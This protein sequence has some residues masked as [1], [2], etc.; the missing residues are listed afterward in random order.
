MDY[1]LS[2]PICTFEYKRASVTPLILDCG[3]TFCSDCIKELETSPTCP[4][5]RS[6]IYREYPWNFPI[7]YSLL[8]LIEESQSIS[9]LN[10]DIV[11]RIKNLKE[12]YSIRKDVLNN[13]KG[14]ICKNLKMIDDNLQ[15]LETM[16]D[17]YFDENSRIELKKQ[18]EQMEEEYEQFP[19]NNLLHFEELDHYASF[20]KRKEGTIKA[21]LRELYEALQADKVYAFKP[22]EKKLKFGELTVRDNKILVHTLTLDEIP[23]GSKTVPFDDMKDD[24]LWFY[25]FLNIRG[26]CHTSHLIQIQLVSNKTLPRFIKLCTGEMGHTYKNGHLRCEGSD[27]TT[28]D[29]DS[30]E[31]TSPSNS[32]NDSLVMMSIFSIIFPEEIKL[33]HYINVRSLFPCEKESMIIREIS[34]NSFQVME[35]CIPGRYK[36]LGRVVYPFKSSD[37]YY[38]IFAI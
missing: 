12:K 2:C 15:R 7:N 3:H 35:V 27:L 37:I 33:D 25:S 8:S 13:E 11:Y 14:K 9:K 28:F 18:L 26:G 20:T 23:K 4:N 34:V 10:I 31:Q 36:I 38:D 22:I 5:C 29:L 32:T 1:I 21:L 6:V 16:K 19:L 30:D 17:C 24:N